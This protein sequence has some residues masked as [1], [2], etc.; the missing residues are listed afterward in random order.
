MKVQHR[1]HECSTSHSLLVPTRS[2]LAV[3]QPRAHFVGITTAGRNGALSNRDRK[4]LMP[5]VEVDDSFWTPFAFLKESWDVVVIDSDSWEIIWSGGTHQFNAHTV[6]HAIALA[7]GGK[8][9]ADDEA[10][11]AD[12]GDSSECSTGRNNDAPGVPPTIAE[13][14]TAMRKAAAD[15][16]FEKAAE[17]RDQIQQLE[18]KPGQPAKDSGRH[19]EKPTPKPLDNENIYERDYEEL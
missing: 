14:R 16:N 9:T 19:S 8:L 18:K 6:E 11:A 5:V 15:L 10:C 1:L 4:T 7:T 2:K 17:L 13:L 3:E 12:S